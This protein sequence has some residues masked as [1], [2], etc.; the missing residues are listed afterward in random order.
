MNPSVGPTKPA[1]VRRHLA[2]R[3]SSASFQM[4]A[5]PMAARPNGPRTYP[6]QS[7]KPSPVPAINSATP[8]AAMP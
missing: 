5:P 6:I 1:A 2:R 8:T 7:P 3:A 4:K